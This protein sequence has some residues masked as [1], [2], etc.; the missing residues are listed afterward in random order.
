MKRGPSTY[1]HA[2]V[3]WCL[4]LLLEGLNAQGITGQLQVLRAAWKQCQCNLFRGIL[5]FGV[6][7]YH[8]DLYQYKGDC[9]S[10]LVYPH[11][12]IG[13][14]A[15]GD[16][17]LTSLDATIARSSGRH[18]NPLALRIFHPSGLNVAPSK[19][20]HGSAIVFGSNATRFPYWSAD[21]APHYTP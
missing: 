6:T 17:K 18:N 8:T 15:A 2:A 9:L 11:S 5:R 3:H 7:H 1:L 20:T 13:S 12:A 16:H 14:I 19:L 10:K 21:N 4:R